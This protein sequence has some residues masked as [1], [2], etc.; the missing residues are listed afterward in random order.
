LQFAVTALDIAIHPNDRYKTD[1]VKFE[2]RRRERSDRGL[3]PKAFL[4][5]WAGRETRPDS[6]SRMGRA[7]SPN[8]SRSGSRLQTNQP[9][10]RRIPTCSCNRLAGRGQAQFARVEGDIISD[11]SFAVELP[12][13]FIVGATS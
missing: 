11:I 6:A 8:S 13:R 5:K 2:R 9:F 4:L 7:R 3:R 10:R 1:L 12:E